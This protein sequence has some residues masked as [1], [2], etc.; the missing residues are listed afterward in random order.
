M[1]HKLLLY[2]KTYEQA[3]WIKSFLSPSS[4]KKPSNGASFKPS[5]NA[6]F[7]ILFQK[8]LRLN[9]HFTLKDEQKPWIFIS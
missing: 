9:F 5:F 6:I 7:K 2:F 8:K 3:F 1:G 4:N